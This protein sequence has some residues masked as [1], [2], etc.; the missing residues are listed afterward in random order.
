VLVI[1]S[2]LMAA[3]IL[4]REAL[5]RPISGFSDAVDLIIVLAAAACFP[6]SL[7][8]RQH[9]AVR[10]AGLV[11]WRMR[12]ALDLVGHVCMLFVFAVI[13]WQLAVYTL[14]LWASGQT[15]W[16][17][18]VPIWPV[19]T[20]ATLIFMFCVPVQLVQVADGAARLFSRLPPADEADDRDHA[21]AP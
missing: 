16:L 11:H 7:A 12:E 6:A 2:L 1:L 15:T 9:V 4:G 10:F 14:D 3:D 13:A 20:L 18:R 8:N 5:G 17:V 19:W 21:A